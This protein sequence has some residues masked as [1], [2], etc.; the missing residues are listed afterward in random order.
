[1][2]V[3]SRQQLD[4]IAFSMFSSIKIGD[5][6]FNAVDNVRDLGAYLDSNMTMD[7]HIEAKCS[8]AF[9]AI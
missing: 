3:G 9:R 8:S 2:I 6:I 5:S 4:K 1:M 7:K